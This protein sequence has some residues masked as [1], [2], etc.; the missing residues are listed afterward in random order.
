MST[1]PNTRALR[2]ASYPDRNPG[3]PYIDLFYCALARHGIEHVGR[4]VPDPA[5][6]KADGSAVDVV[7]IHWPERIWRGKRRGRLDSAVAWATARSARGVWR[8]R[9]FLERQPEMP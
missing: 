6:F 1:D 7:H 2:L 5:W 3:N 4:L 9:R 8:L